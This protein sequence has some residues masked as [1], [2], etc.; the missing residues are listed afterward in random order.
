MVYRQFFPPQ[1][2]WMAWFLNCINPIGAFFKSFSFFRKV[3]LKIYHCNF[4]K[5]SAKIW[6]SLHLCFDVFKV[7]IFWEGRKI[8][9]NPPLTFDYSTYSQGKGKISQNF[10][11]FSI[12]MNF[13]VMVLL[14]YYIM[15]CIFLISSKNCNFFVYFL[16]Y[17][18]LVKVTII[19]HYYISGNMRMS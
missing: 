14:T 13:T 12:Y 1:L 18:S 19:C 10:V 17:K 2:F 3:I 7:H 11:A 5:I 6:S 8:L 16:I 15:S 4:E 9:R